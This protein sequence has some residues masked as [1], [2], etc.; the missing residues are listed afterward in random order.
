MPNL[1]RFHQRVAELLDS[2]GFA[3]DPPAEHQ[4]LFSLSVD[5]AYALHLG[6]MNEEYWFILAELPDPVSA[7]AP[8][9]DW[10]RVNALSDQPLRPVLALDEH[11]HPCC[12][13]RLP[14]EGIDVPELLQAFN[15]MLAQADYLCGKT[16]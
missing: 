7:D 8:L 2:I 14:V 12:Y 13:L 5:Q 10:L 3:I 15:T 1:P 11:N 9:D 6:M 4:D 16:S